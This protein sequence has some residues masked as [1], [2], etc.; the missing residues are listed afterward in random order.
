MDKKILEHVLVSPLEHASVRQGA[1]ELDRMGH[2]VEPC[3][4]DASGRLSLDD[5]AKRL[6]P[7]TALVSVMA[8][9][10]LTSIRQP[11]EEIAELLLGHGAFFHS[12][13]AQEAGKRNTAFP[14]RVDGLSIS[15]HKTYGPQEI[16]ACCVRKS[17]TEE[18][19]PLFLAG[20]QQRGRRGGTLPVAL[21]AGLAKRPFKQRCTLQIENRVVRLL[22]MKFVLLWRNV[23]RKFWVRGLRVWA[24]TTSIGLRMGWLCIFQTSTWRWRFR[25]CRTSLT[26]RWAV[27]VMRRVHLRRVLRLAPWA[28]R[29]ASRRACC[30]FRGVIR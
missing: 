27:R 21:I 18:V 26:F 10:N 2:E 9:S 19:Q 11:L 3:F 7:E 29:C 15:A 23:G 25:H 8:V 20:G 6:R 22:A 5:F 4:C 1:A 14:S 28:F 17:R 13:A 16:G 12:D 24:L 30:D